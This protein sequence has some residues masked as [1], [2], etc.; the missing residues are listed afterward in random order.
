MAYQTAALRPAAPLCAPRRHFAHRG[1]TLRSKVPDGPKKGG[2][3]YGGPDC[4][5]DRLFAFQSAALRSKVPVC[6]SQR[7]FGSRGA[8]LLSEAPLCTRKRLFAF[9]G[10]SLYSEAPLCFLWRRFAFCSASLPS[11]GIVG[12]RWCFALVG[13]STALSARESAAFVTEAP[14]CS[15]FERRGCRLLTAP[16]LSRVYTSGE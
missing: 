16:R 12:R 3:P 13:E 10:A 4:S 8:T 14:L 15:F 9:C 6:L 1:A 5:P 2:L 11:G 7:L